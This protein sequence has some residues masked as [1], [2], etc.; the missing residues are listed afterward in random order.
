MKI[1]ALGT[2][3]SGRA[4]L[5]TELKS[6]RNCSH[7]YKRLGLSCHHI[8]TTK[9]KPTL[10][11]QPKCCLLSP[12][13]LLL[14]PTDIFQHSFHAYCQFKVIAFLV[15][16]MPTL[17]EWCD[18]ALSLEDFSILWSVCYLVTVC[19][20]LVVEF[21]GNIQCQRCP[22]NMMDYM[23]A[24]I[25]SS[26]HSVGTSAEDKL[27]DNRLSG[28]VLLVLSVT[29]AIKSAMNMRRLPVWHYQ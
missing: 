19:F 13:F 14:A 17:Q 3:W 28:H 12:A 4:A 27:I 24:V 5:S 22:I 26:K 8:E 6:L 1:L 2:V 7:V 20:P 29:N 16:N 11:R 9:L 23:I 15:G 10:S 21:T 25:A 18:H